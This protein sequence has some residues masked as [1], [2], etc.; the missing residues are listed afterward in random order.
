MEGNFINSSGT[1]E[2]PVPVKPR[3]HPVLFDG[4]PD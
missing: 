4:H 1:I 2:S 3:P